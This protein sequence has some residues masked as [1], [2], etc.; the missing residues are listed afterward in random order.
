LLARI[1]IHLTS[2]PGEV[3]FKASPEAVVVRD[4][5]GGFAVEWCEFAPVPALIHEER[6]KSIDLDIKMQARRVSQRLSPRWLFRLGP[7]PRHWRPSPL[8]WRDRRPSQQL[9]FRS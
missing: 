2:R 4:D 8:Q 5:H 3:N 9:D 6:A 1:R 7:H